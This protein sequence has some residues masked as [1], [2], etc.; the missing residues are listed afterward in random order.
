M[1]DSSNSNP[2]NIQDGYFDI[3]EYETKYEAEEVNVPYY[4]SDEE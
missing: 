2:N 4:I 1:P 3:E